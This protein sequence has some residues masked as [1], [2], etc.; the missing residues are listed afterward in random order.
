MNDGVD[1][2]NNSEEI[3]IAVCG[4]VDAGKSTIIGVL[5]SGELDNGKGYARNK[6]LIHPHEIESGRTSNITFNPLIYKINDNKLIHYVFNDFRNKKNSPVK[7][8]EIELDKSNDKNRKRIVSFVDL[9]GHEKYLK[10]TVFGVSGLFPNYGL[11]IIGS[12][13]GITKLTREHIGILFYLN[14]PFIICITKIDLAPRHV[15]QQL[16]NR[17]KKLLGSQVYQKIT[18]FISDS[19]KKDSETDN[20]LK[21]F[22]NNRDVVP[23]ISI[24]NKDGTN[25]NNLHKILAN[26][27]IK[28][29]WDNGDICDEKKGSIVYIDSNF[30]VPGIGLVVSGSVKG[31]TIKVK[32]K[33]YI[34]PKNGSFYPVIVRSIHNSIS[35][36]TLEAKNETQSC[37]AIKYCNPKNII[38]RCEIKKGMVLIDDI[39]KWKKNVVRSFV[40]KITVLQHS[41][42]IKN[43]YSPVI[44]CGPIR[45]AAKLKFIKSEESLGSSDDIHI[46]SGDTEKVIFKFSHHSEFIEGNNIFFFMDGN[47]KGVGKVINLLN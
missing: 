26:I 21:E 15:Y 14:I 28:G 9:A 24:S 4:P 10:T 6:V 30:L 35:Q 27:K 8:Q 36:V 33:M 39:D 44:H 5:T 13:T 46:R 37:F 45:Q 17:I 34:G 32:D 7:K 12:N 1:S 25:I 40:A 22:I 20:Y 38:E 3:T 2:T 18:Y 11:I 47:T 23:V 43:G 42:T 41:T 31:K 29:K 16:C 19:D